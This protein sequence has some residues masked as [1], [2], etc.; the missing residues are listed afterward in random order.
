MST[1]HE[2]GGA[3][4]DSTR[5]D[6]DE[7][8]ALR[9]LRA[10]GRLRGGVALLGPAFVAA[11]AYIDPGNFA[12]NFTAGA[13][14]GYL[15]LWVIVVANLMAMLVQYLSAKVGVATGRDLP[16]LCREHLPKPVSR[17][18]WVQ[19]EIVAM[20]TDL[21]EIV[22]AAVG[23]NLLFNVPLF[24][25]GVIAVVVAFA[26]LA[27][28]QRGYRRFELAIAGLLGIVFLGF[29]YNL[30][31]VG[32]DPAGVAA[33]LVPRIEGSDSLLLIAGIIGATVMPH[34]VY[35]HSA[36]TKRRVACRDDAERRE[37]LRFQRW[38]VVIG[39]GAAGV[40]NLSMLVIA[41]SLFNR[42]GRS[43]VDSIES[44]HAGL[45]ELVGGGAALAFAVALLAS[46]LSSSSVGTYAGQVVMQGFIRRQ[47]PLF[48]RR[49]L[50]ML[51]ALVVLGLGLP[52]T[53]SLVISQVV[54]SF[55]IPFALVPL[56]MLTRRADIM[57]SFVNRPMTT[58]VASVIAALIIALNVFLVYTTVV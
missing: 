22:G 4:I 47:I 41:A 2:D 1:T 25:A 57:G 45:G 37:V 38:D 24:P 46:G 20:A 49:G 30:V 7:A 32:A 26:I 50:T 17:G 48:V 51:P 13:S 5:P 12:T 34:V 53:D 33:G 28:E 10:R 23:L 56:I 21:A 3:V 44:A 8:S 52:V 58:V 35:L 6:V 14:Y 40:I 11:V 15:L 43:D 31:A 27:L 9:A 19:A 39:L 55:G 29:L 16:E 42:T 18:L 36:L 54:L